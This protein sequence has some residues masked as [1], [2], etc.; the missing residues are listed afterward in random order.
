MAGEFNLEAD[1]QI[2]SRQAQH[3]AAV[4]GNLPL[5]EQAAESMRLG[6]FTPRPDHDWGIGEKAPG[7]ESNPPE[8]QKLDRSPYS[9]PQEIGGSGG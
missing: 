4:L 3:L 6:A 5:A 7:E 9:S 8:A 2:D 1:G